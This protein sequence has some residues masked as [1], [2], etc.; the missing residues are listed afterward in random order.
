MIPRVIE[1]TLRLAVLAWNVSFLAD[2]PDVKIEETEKDVV[3]ILLPRH[4][5]AGLK[6]SGYNNRT[7]VSLLTP[8]ERPAFTPA[9]AK[10]LAA[11]VTT[12]FD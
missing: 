4:I 9:A 12:K 7:L 3:P 2:A 10:A 6:L 1:L 8:A 11:S 5:K